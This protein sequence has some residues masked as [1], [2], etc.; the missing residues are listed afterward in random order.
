MVAT[1]PTG[2][3]MACGRSRGGRR[4]RLSVKRST[5]SLHRVDWN[6]AAASRILRVSDKTLL[7]KIVDCGLRPPGRQSVIPRAGRASR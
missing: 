5:T 1:G 2:P 4:G 6:R 7:Q 3:P